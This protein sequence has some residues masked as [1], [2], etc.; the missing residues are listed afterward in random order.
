MR[1]EFVEMLPLMKDRVMQIEHW[2]QLLQDPRHSQTRLA[3]TSMKGQG[4]VNCSASVVLRALAA[5]FAS[6]DGQS[7]LE[8]VKASLRLVLPLELQGMCEVLAE[9]QL[10]NASCIGKCQYHFA[11]AT[12]IERDLCW[13]LLCG[14]LVVD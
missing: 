4:N 1:D 6:K 2:S 8:T 7:Y 5:A 14:P 9:S 12:E 3:E 10:P 13:W 11:A